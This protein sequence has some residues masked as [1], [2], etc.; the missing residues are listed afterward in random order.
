MNKPLLIAHRGDTKNHAENT[1]AAFAS[2]FQKGADGIE[3]D[4][5][6]NTL[7]QPVV[8][9][10]YLYDRGGTYPLLSDVL[11]KFH[12]KGRIEVE[13]KSLEDGA[14]KRISDVVNA[15]RPLDL[16]VT[17]SVLPLLPDMAKYFP[18]DKRG[19]IFRKWL[20]EEWMPSDFRIYW[21]MRHLK[22]SR[23]TV[24]HLDL[25]FYDSDLIEKLHEAGVTAHTHLTHSAKEIYDRVCELGIDQCTFDDSGVLEYREGLQTQ[26]GGMK[27][28]SQL[29]D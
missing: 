28:K 6:I 1:M 3:L 25:D 29:L 9:H 5:H 15:F 2:A 16:E 4:V 13:I 23:A 12:C 18:Q 22:L 17:T 27:T 21:I 20:I 7:G 8:V 24:L 11:E 10:N 26:T 14:I 19:L